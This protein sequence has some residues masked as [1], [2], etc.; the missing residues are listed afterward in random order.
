MPSRAP[1]DW[2][3]FFL[4]DVR[5]GLGPYIGVF[6]LTQ[7]SW[8]QAEI[9][10]LAT[11][12]GLAGLIVQT[13][14]GAFIDA[15]RWKRGVVVA[16]VGLLTASALAIAAV[17]SFPIVLTAQITMAVAGAGPRRHDRV[18]VLFQGRRASHDTEYPVRPV[19]A[20]TVKVCAGH[21]EI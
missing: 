15:A 13:P 12:G 2:L 19:V 11:A 17:P 21:S 20:V 14:L 5:G 6:L 3:N 1:L 16:G 4:A 9:G 10:L 18:L 7:H 8:N